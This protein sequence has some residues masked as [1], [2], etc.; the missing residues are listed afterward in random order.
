[1]PDGNVT[2]ILQGKKRFEID[3]VITEESLSNAEVKE[4]PE[5]RPRKTRYRVCERL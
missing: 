3:K 2:V 4:V 5:K 1:M